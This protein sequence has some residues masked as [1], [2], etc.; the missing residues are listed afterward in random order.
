MFHLLIA[1]LLMGL[2]PSVSAAS[3][4]VTG[5]WTLDFEQ[6]FGGHPGT[7]ECA[8][9]QDGHKVAV[10]CGKDPTTSTGEVNDRRVT[11]ETKTGL[12][13]EITATFAAD[14]DPQS[15]T[16][17]GMWRLPDREGKF[18]ARKH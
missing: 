9:K 7:S 14:L 11:W 13:R 6:D 10:R 4:E 2:I 18:T 17:T 8:F 12:H 1:A 15:K 5:V 3:D 16:M